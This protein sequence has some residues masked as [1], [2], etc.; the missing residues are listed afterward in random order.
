[1]QRFPI[2]YTGSKLFM[3]YCLSHMYI[4]LPTGYMYNQYFYSTLLGTSTANFS[5]P[6]RI[7]DRNGCRPYGKW[8][9]RTQLKFSCTL[10]VP[11][12]KTLLHVVLYMYLSPFVQ[13]GYQLV[14]CR[15]IINIL[16]A[17]PRINTLATRVHE[18]RCF[19]VAEAVPA[20]YARGRSHM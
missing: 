6:Y 20:H 15:T 11:V 8:D 18:I 19:K 10:K 9:F 5:F 13:Y 3:W 16:L 7:K 2:N 17:A 1:M 14:T 4:Q 12:E